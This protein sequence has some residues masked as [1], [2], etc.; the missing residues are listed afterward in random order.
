M[1]CGLVLII[2]CIDLMDNNGQS[3]GNGG[4][5]VLFR[6]VNQYLSAT[7]CLKVIVSLQINNKHKQVKKFKGDM[8]QQPG[9]GKHALLVKGPRIFR[10]NNWNKQNCWRNIHFRR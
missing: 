2:C 4:D 10:V 8:N 1:I 5:N 7:S 3:I 6:E 9:S